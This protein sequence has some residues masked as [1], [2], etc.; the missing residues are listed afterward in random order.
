MAGRTW[1]S[2][3]TMVDTLVASLG[4]AKAGVIAEA[5][6][7]RLYPKTKASAEAEL[8]WRHFYSGVAGSVRAY[9]KHTA[10]PSTVDP[11][12]F[13]ARHPE[14]FPFIER[15]SHTSYYTP[16]QDEYV[17]IYALCENPEMLDSAR[18][19]MRQKG[20]EVLAEADLLDELYDAVK[21]GKT[22]PRRR[23]K[24]AAAL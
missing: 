16:A 14:L 1:S 5:V 15:L 22:P 17:S 9:L 7:S 4:T 6:I 10:S 20:V 19:F 8:A 13:F 21:A 18:R 3:E 24:K 12:T 23:P 11:D 2:F